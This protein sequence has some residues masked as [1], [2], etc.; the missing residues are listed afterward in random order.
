MVKKIVLKNI[1]ITSMGTKKLV[2]IPIDKVRTGELSTDK[3]YHLIFVEAPEYVCVL[4]GGK[5]TSTW[6]LNGGLCD[7]CVNKDV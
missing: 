6:E 4:C 5:L 7:G 3:N 1:K 2:T